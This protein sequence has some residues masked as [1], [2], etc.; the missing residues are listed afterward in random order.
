MRSEIEMDNVL[1]FFQGVD[2]FNITK[3][4]KVPLQS[5]LA[6]G[7]KVLNVSDV[8]VPITPEW[9][10]S[11]RAVGSAP[12]FSPQPTLSL[13]LLRVKPWKEATW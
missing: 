11:A 3:L 9:M 12:E 4:A 13:R 2:K 5:L 8:H 10:D 7:F 1:L 6:E